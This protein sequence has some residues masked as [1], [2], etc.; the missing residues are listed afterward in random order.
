[1]SFFFGCAGVGSS[2][3]SNWCFQPLDSLLQKARIIPDQAERTKLYEEAQVIIKR[4]APIA[5]LDHSTV[6]MPMSKKVSGYVLDPLGSH[7]FDG[8]D[9]AE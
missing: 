2:N 4:E 7:R 1:M 5:A 8:V 9:L 3:Y 6:V